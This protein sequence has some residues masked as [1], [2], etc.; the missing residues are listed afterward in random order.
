MEK[1]QIILDVKADL[2][3]GPF[4]DVTRKVLYWVNINAGEVHI[5]DPKSGD[6]TMIPVGKMIGTL[7]V[8]ENGGLV[9]ALEDGFYFLDEESGEL[10][11]IADPEADK[12]ENRFN[13]GKCDP[14]GRFWA[15]T[16]GITHRNPTGALHRLSA[17]NDTDA[18]S[19]GYSVESMIEGVTVSNGIV[20]SPDETVMYFND[21]PTGQVA[22]FDYDKETGN[23]RNR[24]VVVTIPEGEGKPDGMAIDRE[25]TLWIAQ[26]GGWKVARWDPQTGKQLAEISIP[27]G[28]VTACAFGGK[29]LDE[30]YITTARTNLDE[31]ALAEQLHAGSMFLVKTEVQGLPFFTFKG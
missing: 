8:R 16:M 4:W 18:G 19:G 30:L 13:D 25:G 21:S 1:A 11:F 20:W 2:G 17:A 23:I 9:V 15:G 31:A 27:V 24:R 28:Q 22:A 12:P 6:D 26:F 3:E 14:A 7:V 29:N 5:F 10:T